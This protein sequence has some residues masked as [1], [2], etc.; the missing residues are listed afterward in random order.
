MRRSDRK[1]SGFTLIELVMGM[2]VA[3]VVLLA[4]ATFSFAMR[5][6]QETTD[7]ML[8]GQAMLRT[9]SLRI[10]ELVRQAVSVEADGGT[11]T[12]QKDSG[13][14]TLT[15]SGSTLLLDG[16]PLLKDCVGLEMEVREGRLLIVRFGHQAE[17]G[18][19]DYEICA[20]ARCRNG[21]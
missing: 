20:A 15:I 7:L 4:A 6:G 8:D 13:P 11:V 14:S 19:R 12:L 1:T 3:G 16:R 17:T 9:A 18:M 2:L 10:T 5:Q 21:G